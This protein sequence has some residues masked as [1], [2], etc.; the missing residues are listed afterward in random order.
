MERPQYDPTSTIGNPGSAAHAREA[1]SYSASPSASG[2]NPFV[3]SA[4]VRSV[5]SSMTCQT[6]AIQRSS[7][8]M[9]GY[10]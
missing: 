1:A 10:P 9:E 8:N 7:A 5:D 2:M 4:I 3:L 6:N